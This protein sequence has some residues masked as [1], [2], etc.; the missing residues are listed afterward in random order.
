MK[1]LSI[2]LQETLAMPTNIWTVG[3]ALTLFAGVIVYLFRLYDASQ[4]KR[5]TESFNSFTLQV[6]R[7]Q[8][9]LDEEKS[10]RKA[11]QEQ[12]NSYIMNQ[13]KESSNTIER[14]EKLLTVVEKKYN[15]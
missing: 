6:N 10:A 14:V 5:Q 7:M 11:L 3:G 2:L 12:M 8:K 13:F 15:L 9:D 1:I 4:E